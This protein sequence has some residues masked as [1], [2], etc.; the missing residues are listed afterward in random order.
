MAY[1]LI[2]GTQLHPGAVLR[3]GR[4]ARAGRTR[5]R[6]FARRAGP[7]HTSARPLAYGLSLSA[8]RGGPVFPSMFIGAAI[9]IAASGIARHELGGRDRHGHRGH[10]RRHA[11]AAVDLDAAR[12]SAAGRRRCGVVTPQVVVAVAVAFVIINVLPVPRSEGRQ[13]PVPRNPRPAATGP[14]VLDYLTILEPAIQRSP[15]HDMSRVSGWRPPSR[16]SLAARARRRLVGAGRRRMTRGPP[17][18]ERLRVQ[19]RELAR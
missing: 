16:A 14:A 2:S 12:R 10:V 4:T 18:F 19:E 11:A 8:F 1:Q 5:S 3:T 17:A 13:N 15:A 9:G 6:L 7:A